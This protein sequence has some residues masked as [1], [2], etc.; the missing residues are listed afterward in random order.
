MNKTQ[1]NTIPFIA[2]LGDLTSRQKRDLITER[3]FEGKIDQLNWKEYSYKP[4]AK[5]KLAHNGQYL[6]ILFNVDE[7]NV[8][9][10]YVNDNDSVWEDSCVEAFI[11]TEKGGEY[12]NFEF[13]CIGTALA[14][15]GKHRDDRVRMSQSKTSLIKRET[16]LGKEIIGKE[17]VDAQWWLLAQIPFDMIKVEKGQTIYCN[18]YKCGDETKYP[19]FVSWQPIDTPKPDFH[20][21]KFFGELKLQ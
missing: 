21:P 10:T 16:S 15:V 2:E 14:G 1:N 4:A 12:F 5:F 7:K 3:G 13:S 17:N 6:F 11:S 19:H 8:R 20:Q 18:F 9:A